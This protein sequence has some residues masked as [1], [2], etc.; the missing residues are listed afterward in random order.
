MYVTVPENRIAVV[1][2]KNGKT[3]KIIEKKGECILEIN[4]DTGEVWI[5]EEKDPYLSYK[6]ADVI[7]AIAHGF[8]PKK[9]FN[10]FKDLYYLEVID[11]GEYAKKNPNRLRR[12]KARLIGRQGRTRKNLEELSS[13]L[14]SVYEDTVSI[15]SDNV[16][17]EIA[18]RA[19]D[20]L[21][22]GRQQHTVYRYLVKKQR[23]IKLA[24]MG[25]NQHKSG[26]AL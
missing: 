17:L 22:I 1:I 13:S 4:S 16:H 11:I 10:L 23:E 19:T 18:K 8:S 24:E 2:G 3:K 12:I 25:V 26:S 20:M 5:K 21:L 15:I 6:T 14:F 9:A 7:R